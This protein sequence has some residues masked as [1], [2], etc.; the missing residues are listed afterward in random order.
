MRI[1]HRQ[2]VG[3]Q[4]DA[5]GQRTVGTCL[6]QRVQRT[7]NAGSL[8]AR[9]VLAG[10]QI[11]IRGIAVGTRQRVLGNTRM[12]AAAPAFAFASLAF[13]DNRDRDI[14]ADRNDNAAGG[15]RQRITVAV[16]HLD[17][18]G[19]VDGQSV[20]GIRRGVRV[21]D[22]SEQGEGQR[23]GRRQ[24]HGEDGNASGRAGDRMAVRRQAVGNRGVVARQAEAGELRQRTRGEVERAQPV[25]ARVDDSRKF[26]LADG[27]LAEV[28]FAATAGV[29]VR[30][31]KA[32]LID[33][34]NGGARTDKRRAV[35]FDG[36]RH[37]GRGAATLAV[38]G[39][40]R[41]GE[42]EV[43]FRARTGIVRMIDRA[44]DLDGVGIAR[45]GDGDDRDAV[46]RAD[47]R[48]STLPAPD[49]RNAAGGKPGRFTEGERERV[50]IRVRRRETTGDQRGI[51]G[52]VGAVSV[53][54]AA[55]EAF[56]R[57][58][59]RDEI[60]EKRITIDECRGKFVLTEGAELQFGRR[61][62]TAQVEAVADATRGVFEIAAGAGV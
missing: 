40:D 15:S 36:D 17:Q 34:E 6:E 47:Q 62:Q 33:P 53:R 7:G 60:G 28:A 31:G 52:V 41:H 48:R 5:E 2:T 42:G 59:K 3:R 16:R 37:V 23:T 22:L 1:E 21:I 45:R 51:G 24:L 38:G 12:N 19:Q 32:I 49:Q 10:I 11:A 26:D 44:E 46:D 61:Q 25:R 18:A 14:V 20:F 30:R 13:A 57:Q 58:R 4:V 35:V 9:R 54:V 29:G 56:F 55:G 50:A 8:V 43:V 27:L 39:R